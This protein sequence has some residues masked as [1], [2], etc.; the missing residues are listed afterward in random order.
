MLKMEKAKKEERKVLGLAYALFSLIISG[1]CWQAP[2]GSLG[3]FSLLFSWGA[4]VFYGTWKLL[5]VL[6]DAVPFFSSEVGHIMF[7]VSGIITLT[8]GVSF[9]FLYQLFLFRLHGELS[10]KLDTRFPLLSICIHGSGSALAYLIRFRLDEEEYFAPF[11]LIIYPICSVMI[12]GYLMI[13]WR[14]AKKIAKAESEAD[15][16]PR[17]MST[18]SRA[19]NKASLDPGG[20][21]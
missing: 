20:D 12:V 7:V 13:D 21:S 2:Q 5:G 14:L 10:R 19:N 15:G 1:W 11:R 17:L 4:A 9:V 6:K 3:P 16:G 18:F 8:I